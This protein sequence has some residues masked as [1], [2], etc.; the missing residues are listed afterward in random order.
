M[1][2]TSAQRLVEEWI[3]TKYLR[4]QFE[5]TFQERELPLIWG[6]LFNFDAVSDDG[7]IAA[8]ISTSKAITRRKRVGQGKFHKI[9]ADTFY[10]LN[11]RDVKRKM[12]IF[13]ERDMY[14]EFVRRR[15]NGRFPPEIEFILIDNIP[16]ELRNGLEASR[17][18]A[19][20]EVAAER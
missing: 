7:T 11:V 10:L 16:L 3:R 6:G 15:D 19:S 9:L 20:L 8:N 12:L 4:E 18:V 2:N 1:A 17:N 14:D 13:T 5:Q